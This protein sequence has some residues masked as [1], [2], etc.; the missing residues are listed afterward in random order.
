MPELGARH[1][2]ELGVKQPQI[3][4][5]VRT[6]TGLRPRVTPPVVCV[7]FP[8]DFSRL[9]RKLDACLANST[10]TF[11]RLAPWYSLLLQGCLYPP[12]DPS[13]G[14]ARGALPSRATS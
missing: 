3:R 2:A 7:S 12:G 5:N 13:C 4:V 14:N 9:G 6:P 11:E 8:S 10:G 1:V